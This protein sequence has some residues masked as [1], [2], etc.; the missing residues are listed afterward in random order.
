KDLSTRGAYAFTKTAPGAVAS[1][2]TAGTGSKWRTMDH[3]NLMRRKGFATAHYLIGSHDLDTAAKSDPY[4]AQR[5]QGVVFADDPQARIGMDGKSGETKGGY[6]SNPFKTIQDRNVMVTM[7]WGP[8][9]DRKTDPHLW[10][11]FSSTL[12]TVEE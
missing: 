2:T 8:I 9:I 3:E 7:K 12:D 6:I 11:Y 10:I 5:W 4:R 1:G